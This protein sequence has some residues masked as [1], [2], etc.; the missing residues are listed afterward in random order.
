MITAGNNLLFGPSV[1]RRHFAPIQQLITGGSDEKVAF[2]VC[3]LGNFKGSQRRHIG[4]SKLKRLIGMKISEWA[5]IMCQITG[6]M[7]DG[8]ENH[9]LCIGPL[10]SEVSRS[11]ERRVGIDG[12]RG[13]HG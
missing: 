5:D 10:F 11:E 8:V 1:M 2:G 3:D 9:A 6:S 12:S 7:H 13:V 4:L